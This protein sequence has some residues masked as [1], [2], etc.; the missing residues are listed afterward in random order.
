MNDTQRLK[1]YRDA[2]AS[3]RMPRFESAKLSQYA[4]AARTAALDTIDAALEMTTAPAMTAEIIDEKT[5]RDRGMIPV[6]VVMPR[7]APELRTV[8]ADMRRGG[9]IHALVLE[10]Q[11]KSSDANWVAVWRIPA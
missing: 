1:D 8:L 10:D 11:C 4:N 3:V 6:T 9:S 7:E 5:A 2:L